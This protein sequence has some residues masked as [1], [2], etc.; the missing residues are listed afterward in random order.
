MGS[1]LT[2]TLVMKDY[3]EM[4]ERREKMERMEEGLM[5]PLINKHFDCEKGLR[6]KYA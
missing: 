1:M 2:I 5:K 3:R 4:K 6:L